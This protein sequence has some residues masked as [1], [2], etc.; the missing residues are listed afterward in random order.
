MFVSQS[1]YAYSYKEDVYALGV[2]FFYAFC[3]I[4]KCDPNNFTENKDYS[5]I[6]EIISKMTH[7]VKLEDIEK[8]QYGIYKDE[9][10]FRS[11]LT[12]NLTNHLD[13]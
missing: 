4:T 7:P 11:F 9:H 12:D 2:T 6:L 1:S 10:L 3:N 5:D 8:T 13:A